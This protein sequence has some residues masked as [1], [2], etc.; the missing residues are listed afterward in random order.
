[1][2]LYPTCCSFGALCT[3]RYSMNRSNSFLPYFFGTIRYPMNRSNVFLSYF[4]Q[5][6]VTCECEGFFMGASPD[7]FCEFD[8]PPGTCS[9]HGSC[10][11]F[12]GSCDCVAGYSVCVCVCVYL[13]MHLPV[14]LFMYYDAY[15]CADISLCCCWFYCIDI[16]LS[17]SLS[18][19]TVPRTLNIIGPINTIILIRM[20]T[21]TAYAT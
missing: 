14:Y 3:I 6:T 17:L 1:M 9:G 2:V 8:C 10:N 5:T 7:H 12:T 13:S 11:P 18:H 20:H 21:R 19:C 15:G 16:Y 4:L